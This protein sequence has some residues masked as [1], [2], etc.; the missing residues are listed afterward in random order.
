MAVLFFLEKINQSINQSIQMMFGTD[1]TLEVRDTTRL[2]F[3]AKDLI[4]A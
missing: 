3:F 1:A 2:A 4:A